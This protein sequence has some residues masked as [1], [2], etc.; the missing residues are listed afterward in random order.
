MTRT[1]RVSFY[2]QK[3][4]VAKTTS[5]AHTAV[6][7]VQDH[8]FDVVMLDLAGTQND[9]AAHFGLGDDVDDPDAPIS[10]VFGDDWEFIA[11]NIDDVAER[12]IYAT[13]EGPDL[14]PADH[15][16]SGADNNLASV[17]VEERYLKLETFISDQLADR[18]DLVVLDLPGKEDNI[19]LNGILAASDIVAPLSPGKFELNQLDNLQAD[20][21]SITA[22]LEGVLERLGI[23]LRLAMVIPTQ[24]DQR[25]NQAETFVDEIETTYPEIAGEPVAKSQN[26]SQ[27]QGDGKTLFAVSDGS[28][29]PTGQRARDA[30]RT[31]TSDLLDRLTPR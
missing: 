24:I 8:D 28:L 27:L 3:G 10:A 5:A 23:Q 22:D 14:I 18:Y 6:A 13:D 1:R 17:P 2:V 20:I 4:G 25:T 21:A 26:V 11:D 7:A 30:Y 15:G 16:L 12:M 31:N 9:L 29:Y 19:T